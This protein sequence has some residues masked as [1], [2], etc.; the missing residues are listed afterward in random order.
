MKRTILI[1]TLLAATAAFA[2]PP[3]PDRLE[4]ML[5]LT[6]EQKAA[7]DAARNDFHNANEALFDR[8]RSA[9]QQLHDAL[10]AK[11][12][13]PCAVGTAMVSL[14]AVEEQ[15]RTA[16]Q[17]LDQKLEA[18]LTP[19]QKAKFES[20]PPRPPMPPPPPRY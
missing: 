14:H 7:W 2:Q 3:R 19:E 8:E 9:Q 13:D 17:A 15:L 20:R 16:H 4:T 18:L 5:N 11:S 1:L 12:P 10:E 6:A